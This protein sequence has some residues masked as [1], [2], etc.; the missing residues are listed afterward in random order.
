M[1][2]FNEH[3][4][5]SVLTF[6]RMYR[7]SMAE[8]W[9]GLSIPETIPG[10]DIWPQTSP[11][12]SCQHNFQMLSSTFA[13]NTAA[14]RQAAGRKTPVVMASSSE[15]SE[16][17]SSIPHC[18]ASLSGLWLFGKQSLTSTHQ[19]LTPC[20]ICN[21]T[22]SQGWRAVKFWA[23]SAGLSLLSCSQP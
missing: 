23:L 14:M 18:P 22:G 1:R 16:R 7:S 11:D 4:P 21:A 13:T 2:V 12:Y 19:F 6:T 8:I 20:H 3:Q 17:C 9:L 15:P 5:I 10:A